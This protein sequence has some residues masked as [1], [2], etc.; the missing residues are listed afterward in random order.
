MDKVEVSSTFASRAV[1]GPEG[2][3][4]VVC[5]AD[6]AVTQ[7]RPGSFD[8]L[9][10]HADLGRLMLSGGAVTVDVRMRGVM[11]P[12]LVT[13]GTLLDQTG[14]ASV[15][16]HDCQ[17]GDV[18]V[19]PPSG[20]QE[21]CYRGLTS[22]VALLMSMD[23][24]MRAAEPYESLA[25]PAAWMQC[26]RHSLPAAMRTALRRKLRGYVALLQ[27][28]GAA[29][30]ERA[31]ALLRE[32][33]LET[34]FSAML[35]HV[36]RDTRQQP[37]VNSARIVSRV[38]DWLSHSEQP[39]PHLNE[40]CQA[41]GLSRRTLHRAFHGMLGMG[42][43]AYL[44]LRSL[45]AARRALVQAAERPVSVT[46]VALEHGFWELGRFSVA[47]RSM[48]GESPSQTLQRAGGGR[49]PGRAAAAVPQRQP[50]GVDWQRILLQGLPPLQRVVS[51]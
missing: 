15:W 24:L 43:K 38:E 49:P 22:Y 39:S 12:G 20:E 31:R 36:G 35:S 41:L 2:L 27:L 42:P 33:L 48:F 10:F 3:R 7:L 25:E 30:S 45:S 17:S 1:N 47:Y 8:G 16:G 46:R 28:S 11:V 44:R 37:I 13:M 23:E 21:G 4:E 32:E 26:A 40:L 5:G 19:F 34:F 51:A 18:L 14:H 6:V 29:L 9:L 50:A